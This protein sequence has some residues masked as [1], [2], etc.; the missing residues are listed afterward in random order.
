MNRPL[1]EGGLRINPLGWR[2]R[3][4]DFC[5]ACNV[6]RRDDIRMAS[7]VTGGTEKLRLRFAIGLVDVSAGRAGPAG[8]AWIDK[9]HRD[10]R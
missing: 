5:P 10:P 6:A 7:G 4:H 2:V 8:V 9:G 3:Q 1:K